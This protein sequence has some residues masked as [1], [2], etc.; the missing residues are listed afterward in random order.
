MGET[1]YIVNSL[2]CF[3]NSACSDYSYD[4]LLDV[5]FSFYS[6]KEIKIAKELLYNLLRKDLIWR[7]DPEKMRKDL[8]VLLECHQELTASNK[9]AKIVTD[10]YKKMPPIGMSMFAPILSNLAEDI[11]KINELLPKILDIKTDVCN[12]A[13][14]VRQMK[15]DI[16]DIRNKFKNTIS[17]ME[18]AAKDM[19]DTEINVLEELQS[20]RQSIG[21][22]DVFQP[23][24]TVEGISAR[25][26]AQTVRMVH[27]L[28]GNVSTHNRQE[29]ALPVDDDVTSGD[30]MAATTMH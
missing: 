4:S 30:R 7:R 24:E 2:L 25:S 20:F 14:T 18:E 1:D 10:S 9:K 26:Y 22:N 15:M 29:R 17:G 8:Q 21:P 28:E 13:D 12:T 27:S 3:I 6:H 19:H 16:V 5:I 23:T 11:T